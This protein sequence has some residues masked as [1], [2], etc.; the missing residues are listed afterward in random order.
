MR[1]RAVAEACR[2]VFPEIAAGLYTPEEIG[3]EIVQ[4]EKVEK[5]EPKET[6][7][8]VESKNSSDLI[9]QKIMQLSNNGKD[10]RAVRYLLDL[11]GVTNSSEIKSMSKDD[12]DKILNNISKITIEE[13]NA[14]IEEEDHANT[15]D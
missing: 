9:I 6:D 5:V 15:R 3:S 2:F 10:T 13:I 11:I 4:E 12:T 7:V 1:W 14:G 8:I